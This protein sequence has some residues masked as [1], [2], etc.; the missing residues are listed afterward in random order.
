MGI[1][2]GVVSGALRLYGKRGGSFVRERRGRRLCPVFYY[3]RL[4]EGAGEAPS[5][6]IT[7]KGAAPADFC[8]VIWEGGEGTHSFIPLRTGPLQLHCSQW[9]AVLALAKRQQGRGTGTYPALPTCA[10]LTGTV[11]FAWFVLEW[12]AERLRFRPA[13]FQCSS[14]PAR[15]RRVPIPS[16]APTVPVQLQLQLKRLVSSHPTSNSSEVYTRHLEVTPA[17][18]QAA[19]APRSLA[20]VV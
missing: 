4:I 8:S 7:K 13:S 12:C 14:Y 15:A 16:P 6:F 10:V 2:V 20:S 17:F 11:Y 5:Y 9:L 19:A 1:E 18:L 3:G